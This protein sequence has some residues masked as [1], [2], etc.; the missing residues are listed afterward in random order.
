MLDVGDG[1]PSRPCDC[2][3]LIGGDE[4]SP[5]QRTWL[6]GRTIR[7]NQHELGRFT[8]LARNG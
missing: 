3:R 5:A 1:D 7:D 4:F 2:T 8:Q 6:P